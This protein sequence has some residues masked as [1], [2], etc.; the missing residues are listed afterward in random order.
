[1]NNTNLI[2]VTGI[3]DVKDGHGFVRTAGYLAAR[4]DV[5]LSAAQ[6]RQYG[7]RSGDLV[8]GVAQAAADGDAPR[9]S[10]R[11][12]KYRPMARVDTVNGLDPR[13]ARERPDFYALTPLHPLQL[14]RME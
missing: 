4:D 9:T 10:R 13:Q 3:V 1:M 2:D 6:L 14:L 8:T 12:K 7:L 11:E 5:Y